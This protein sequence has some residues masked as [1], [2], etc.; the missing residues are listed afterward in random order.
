M[1]QLGA[2]PRG[3]AVRY[4]S[5]RALRPDPRHLNT[6]GRQSADEGRIATNKKKDIRQPGGGVTTCYFSPAFVSLHTY[7]HAHI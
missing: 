5:Q 2:G 3:G 6:I 4:R 1:A 7:T